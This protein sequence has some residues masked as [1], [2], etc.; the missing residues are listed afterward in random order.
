MYSH[1]HVVKYVVN[2]NNGRDVVGIDRHLGIFELCDLDLWPLATEINSIPGCHKVI[3]CIK[4]GV[5][6]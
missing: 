1:Q 2:I 3:T 4:Y 5:P 6:R